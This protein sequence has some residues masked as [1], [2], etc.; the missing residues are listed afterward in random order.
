MKCSAKCSYL[1]FEKTKRGGSYIHNHRRYENRKEPD[2]LLPKEF[3]QENYYYR[4]KGGAEALYKEKM[5]E[6]NEKHKGKAGKR[7]KIENSDWECL[8]LL[9]D[10]CTEEDMWQV[11]K[12]MEDE[13][14]IEC[15]SAVIHNDEGHI[16]ENG[17]PIYNRHAHINFITVNAEGQQWKKV[18]PKELSKMQDEVAKILKMPRGKPKKETGRVNINHNE[19]RQIQKDRAELSVAW[20]EARK[21]NAQEEARLTE[22]KAD[23]S[24]TQDKLGDVFEEIGEAVAKISSDASDDKLEELEND[25][26]N[27]FQRNCGV[28]VCQTLWERFKSG[29]NRFIERFNE[30]LSNTFTHKNH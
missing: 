30:S 29:F 23:L 11:I 9:N 7:P 19:F 15:Y 18:G 14:G 10:R 12:K 5:V 13:W 25:I 17:E 4:R 1:K 3:R 24:L 22:W 28:E 16:D 20:A 6:Y 8:L 27:A 21:Q 2:Y 26:Q